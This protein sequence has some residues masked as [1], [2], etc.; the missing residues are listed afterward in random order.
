MCA[1]A[2]HG[3]GQPTASEGRQL[4]VTLNKCAP[5]LNKIAKRFTRGEPSPSIE[6]GVAMLSPVEVRGV[7]FAN[8]GAAEQCAIDRLLWQTLRLSFLALRHT[9]HT[10]SALRHELPFQPGR[11]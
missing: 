2:T 4:R 3:D 6:D 5:C 1:G 10:E 11:V 7:P 8:A 9:I